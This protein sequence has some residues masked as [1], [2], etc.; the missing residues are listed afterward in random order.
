[1]RLQALPAFEDNYIW[2]LDDAR[3]AWV[4]DPGDADPVK[5]CLAQDGLSLQGILVTHRHPDHIGGVAE[6]LQAAPHARVVG[7]A[8]EALPFVHRGVA[9]G[10]KVEVLG[11][12]FEVLDVP[13][14]TAGHVAY[15]AAPRD[16]TPLLFCGDT[17][18]FG[19][20]GRLFEGT[21]QQMWTSLNQLAALPDDT[22]VCCAHEYTLSNLRFA[23]AVE[24]DNAVLHSTF[25]R[26]QDLRARGTATVPSTIGQE[27]A[28]NPFLRC[29]VPSVIRAAQSRQSQISSTD[30]AAVFA[31][32]REWKNQFR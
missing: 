29:A 26:C 9:Q 7:P 24:P 16:Q 19:G 2:M 32:L 4:V 28:I 27:R 14:H 6:L 12:A 20:C 21:P 15:F 30:A 11:E 1:M 18:F 22:R 31:V 3:S 25:A 17:L 23:L 5:H 10:D 13:G 8:N